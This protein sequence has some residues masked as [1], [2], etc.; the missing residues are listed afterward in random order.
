MTSIFL[1]YCVTCGTGDRIREATWD[2]YVNSLLSGTCLV[3]G[4][5]C[6]ISQGIEFKRERLNDRYPFA[7]IR[8]GIADGQVADVGRMV[9]RG[10]RRFVI[11]E[12]SYTVVDR[13]TV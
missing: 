6:C 2:D 12:W 8:Y 3:D 10:E 1:G 7:G 4:I 9:R 11:G 13:E 5:A